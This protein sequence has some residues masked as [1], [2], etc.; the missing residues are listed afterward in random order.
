MTEDFEQESHFHVLK[1][2]D[3]HYSAIGRVTSAFSY[4]EFHINQLIWILSDIDDERGACITS[5]IFTFSARTKALLALI[6]L[7]HDEL[8]KSV[9]E[10]DKDSPDSLPKLRAQLKKLFDKEGDP[11]SRKRNRVVHDTWMYGKKTGAI[12]QIR[13][14]ADRKLDYGFKPASIEDVDRWWE[15]IQQAD[16]KFYELAARIQAAVHLL[17]QQAQ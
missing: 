5:N 13:Q 10:A 4:F 1:K 8:P 6:E 2:D 16:Q 11:L 9:R 14:T 15:E 3:P 12:V 17:Q 7:I